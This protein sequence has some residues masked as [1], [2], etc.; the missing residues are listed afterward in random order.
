MA[1]VEGTEHAGPIVVVVAAVVA[2]SEWPFDVAGGFHID[3]AVAV[4]ADAVAFVAG[5]SSA[6]VAGPM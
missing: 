1:A 4:V 6:A 3:Q 5:N 2:S